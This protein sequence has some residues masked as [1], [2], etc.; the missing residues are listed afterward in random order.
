MVLQELPFRSAAYERVLKR[1][2]EKYTED[3][4]GDT[5]DTVTSPDS[6]L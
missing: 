2:L 6:T 1:L 4:K 5:E 3:G